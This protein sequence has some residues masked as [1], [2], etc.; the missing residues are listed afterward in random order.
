MLNVAFLSREQQIYRRGRPGRGLAKCLPQEVRQAAHAVHLKIRFRHLREDGEIIHLLVIDF[1]FLMAPA[2]AR[3]SDHRAVPH[4]RVAQACRQIRRAHGLGR[5]DA[6][7]PRSAR[8]AVRH[9][10]GRLLAVR[11][12]ALDGHII[13]FGE[14]AAEHC[15]DEKEC[16]NALGIQKFRDKSAAGDFCQSLPP[17]KRGICEMDAKNQ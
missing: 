7:T 2:A 8:V 3:Q 10:G 9:I 17:P 14:G 6:G 15:W 5:A 1:V 11:Q 16:S 13:H 12:D 4:V